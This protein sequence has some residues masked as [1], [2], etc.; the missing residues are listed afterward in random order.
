MERL[1]CT[2][3]PAAHPADPG[4]STIFPTRLLSCLLYRISC[5]TTEVGPGS[6]PIDALAASRDDS[7]V[8]V[9]KHFF[10]VG[11]LAGQ[12]SLIGQLCPGL[13]LCLA[14]EVATGLMCDGCVG[15]SGSTLL[16]FSLSSACTAWQMIFTDWRWLCSDH[17]VSASWPCSCPV[18]HP[19]VVSR[20]RYLDLQ[21]ASLSSSTFPLL[22][23]PPAVSPHPQTPQST[24]QPC[25]CSW[26]Q[27]STKQS[28]S[29]SSLSSGQQ[30]PCGR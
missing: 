24:P 4:N 10:G 9:Q 18:V 29:V 8:G 2:P 7:T 12:H 19:C 21:H 17:D 25:C 26:Q 27:H 14:A 23:C 15:G 11:C 22:H 3:P 5:S 1:S 13:R 16:Y 6:F 28:R 30:A 20:Q